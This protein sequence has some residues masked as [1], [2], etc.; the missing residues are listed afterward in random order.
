MSMWF[1]Q[2]VTKVMF[3]NAFVDNGYRD[4]QTEVHLCNELTISIEMRIP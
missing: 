1:I 4:I 3:S 2:F